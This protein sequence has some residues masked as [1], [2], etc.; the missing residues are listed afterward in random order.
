LSIQ[1][2]FPTGRVHVER[3]GVWTKVASRYNFQDL[4]AGKLVMYRRG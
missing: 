4:M 3:Q 1:E 2:T